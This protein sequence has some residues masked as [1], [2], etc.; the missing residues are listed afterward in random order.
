MYESCDAYALIVY[1]ENEDYVEF[2]PE[3]WPIL[4][5]FHD[6]VLEEIPPSLP[7]MCDIQHCIDL[8]PDMDWN[9]VN[10]IW[11]KWASSNVGSDGTPLKSALLINYDPTGPSRL[12]STIYEGSIGA[13]TCAMAAV[14]QFAHQVDRKNL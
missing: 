8:V 7:P 4:Q 5:E 11:D 12:L 10:K 13:A 14:D 9:V 3:V 6:V 1:E 2:P